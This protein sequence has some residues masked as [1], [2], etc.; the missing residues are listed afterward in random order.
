[1]SGLGRALA[2]VT[3][4]IGM[5]CPTPGQYGG[6]IPIDSVGLSA[7][8]EAWC[9][10]KAGSAAAGGQCSKATPDPPDSGDASDTEASAA[11]TDAMADDAAELPE[12]R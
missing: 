7:R 10:A 4:A 3:A 5:H 6:P 1:V 9:Q 12:A 2:V 11:P 8:L